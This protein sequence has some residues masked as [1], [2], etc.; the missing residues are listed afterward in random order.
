MPSSTIAL[1]PG[2]EFCRIKLRGEMDRKFWVCLAGFKW[3]YPC[4]WEHCACSFTICIIG[5]HYVTRRHL[6]NFID[7]L[8]G[9]WATPSVE[10]RSHSWQ[11]QGTIMPKIDPVTPGSAACKTNTLSLCYLPAIRRHLN[12]YIYGT[13]KTIQRALLLTSVPVSD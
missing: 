12:V 5:T 2:R 1:A 10:L 7:W 6:F 11:A 8:I 13:R 9:F 4:L 3:C